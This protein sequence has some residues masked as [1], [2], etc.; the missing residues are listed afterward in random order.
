[1]E[2]DA[3][4]FQFEGKKPK[5]IIEEDHNDHGD[6]TVCKKLEEVHRCNVLL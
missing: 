3:G 1:V 2:Y 4:Q 5:Y 6:P